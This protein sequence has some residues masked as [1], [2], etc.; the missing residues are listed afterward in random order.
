[1]AA[2]LAV[3]DSVA[4]AASAGSGHVARRRRMT[5]EQFRLRRGDHRLRL[6]WKRRRAAGRGEGLPRRGHGVRQAL[7]GRGHPQD[8]VGSAAVPLVPRG[9]AVRDPADRVPRRCARPLRRGRRRRLARLRQHPVRPAEE[10]LRRAGMGRASPTGPTSWR[11]TSTRRPGCSA[12]CASRTCPPTSTV[13][14]SE[15][16]SEMGRGETFNKAPVGV[17]FGTP[18]VEA[19]D[20]Y[21]G[22][23]GPRRTGCISCG[24]C[25]IGCGHNAKNKLTTNYLYLA[26]KLG[27]EIHELHEVYE[28]VPLDGRRV[29]GAC[30]SPR[31]GAAGGAPPP[32]HVHRR[33]GDR[34]RPRV[35]L[36]E[37]AAPPAAQGHADGPV[38]R[39]RQAGPDELRAAPRD[40]PHARRVEARSRARSTSRRGRWRSPPASGPTIRRASSRSTG[41]SAA[42]CSRSLLTYHQHGEQK[43]PV[44]GWLKEL[45]EHPTQVL[46]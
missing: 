20:P 44:A 13:S 15:V 29:R 18:G 1:M 9:R 38:D 40:H 39:A 36:G 7:E 11:P 25:K 2:A 8:P 27:A 17:Y 28:L 10:V 21:F 6:R 5:W 35:R 26:E 30:A 4:A 16:A 41:A 22:G 3:V 46:G 45:I 23:V 37:A 19:D 12:S 33:A 42:T 34:L 24:N 43:H 14:C 31:L 32:P